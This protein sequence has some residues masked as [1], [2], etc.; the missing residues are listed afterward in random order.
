MAQPDMT[1]PAQRESGCRCA[2]RRP[3]PE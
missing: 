1:L 3:V 2:N